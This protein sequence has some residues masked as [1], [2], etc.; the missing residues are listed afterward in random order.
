MTLSTPFP[1]L[2]QAARKGGLNPLP[3]SFPILPLGGWDRKGAGLVFLSRVN[4]GR[5]GRKGSRN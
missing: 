2:S 3:S 1:L 4:V 5:E